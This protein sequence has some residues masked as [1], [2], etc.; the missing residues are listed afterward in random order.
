[1]LAS[2]APWCCQAAQPLRS[3]GRVVGE[4]VRALLRGEAAQAPAPY[5]PHL[6]IRA[7][8]AAAPSRGAGMPLA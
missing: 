1:M 3:R 7:S 4:L 2:R 5:A 8:T 6:V